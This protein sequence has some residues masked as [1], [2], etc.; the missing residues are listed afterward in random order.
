MSNIS[1]KLH[2]LLIDHIEFTRLNCSRLASKIPKQLTTIGIWLLFMIIGSNFW[3][4]LGNRYQSNSS[5]KRLVTSS[6]ALV[7]RWPHSHGINIIPTIPISHIINLKSIFPSVVSFDC[8][9]RRRE[10]HNYSSICSS[11][12][13]QTNTQLL[14]PFETSA[15]LC[16]DA[17]R[18]ITKNGSFKNT[19][20][21]DAQSLKRIVS[22]ECYKFIATKKLNSQ[23]L[24]ESI[25][26]TVWLSNAYE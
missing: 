21:S 22:N 15:L 1:W 2:G 13:Q 11:I 18:N 5:S 26:L 12:S 9:A 14:F 20:I 23:W 17:A 6:N 8:N 7:S 24:F 3:I 16:N 25:Y 4:S 10:W 19:E